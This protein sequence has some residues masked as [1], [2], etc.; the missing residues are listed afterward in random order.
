MWKRI[1]NWIIKKLGGYT[2][3][4]FSR[5]TTPV[6]PVPE[7]H[8][9]VRTLTACRPVCVPLSGEPNKVADFERMIK[10]SLTHDILRMVPAYIEFGYREDLFVGGGR[11][12]ARAVLHVTEKE[13]SAE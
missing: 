5:V 7:A 9:K 13:V 4:E 2:K 10:D 12:E 3:E 1:K 8:N 6:L 11:G